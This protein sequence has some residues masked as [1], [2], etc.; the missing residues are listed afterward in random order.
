MS[1]LYIRSILLYSF[2]I[3]NV[4]AF[5]QN[6][7]A[8]LK[9]LEKVPDNEKGKILLQLA[10]L[11]FDKNPERA[12]EYAKRAAYI[13][14][15]VADLNIEADAQNISG[16]LNYRKA[17][18]REAA[19]YYEQELK[20]RKKLPVSLKMANAQYNLATIY[21]IQGDAK[22]ANTFFQSSLEIAK[23]KKNITLQQKIYYE[24]YKVAEKR[25]KYDEA[26]ANL[27]AYIELE[28]A[29]FEKEKQEELAILI[30]EKQEFE[31][32]VKSK[33]STLKVVDSTLKIVESEKENLEEL[34]AEQRLQ[35]TNMALEKELQNQELENSKLIR[36]RMFIV[37]LFVI[38][39][40]VLIFLRYLHK[41]K[42]NRMLQAKNVEISQQKEEI[43]AQRD[44][45]QDLNSELRNK[46]EE[47]EAQRDLIERKNKDITDSI[48]YAQRIQTSV[49][50]NFDILYSAFTDWFIFYRP[51]DIVS[52]DFYWSH[53]TDDKIV[54]AVADCTGHG[55][56]GAFMSML[57]MAFLNEI[58][59]QKDITQADLVLEVLR[60]KVKEFLN[61]AKSQTETKDGMDIALVSHNISTQTAQF[62]GANNPLYLIRNNE[63]IIYKPVRNPIGVYYSEKT[64]EKT[65]IKLETNDLMY[66]FSDG[67]ADQFGGV[68]EEKF[69]SKRFQQLFADVSTLKMGEQKSE[70]EQ[71]L[72]NWMGPLHQVDDILILGVRV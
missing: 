69:K 15:L 35:I 62:A 61:Q 58:V 34:T 39:L 70:I 41:Q 29:F 57:G 18:Y 53:K 54:F 11:N 56:P 52:G 16:T 68:K 10:T 49:L 59:V 33:D 37:I 72:K 31:N 60:T 24:L 43:E 5:A 3:I 23:S 50:P 46:N 28:D 48:I 7:E 42:S 22:K 21:N 17:K 12:D 36:Q 13:G 51:R 44:N 66:L 8:L 4:L 38:A 27:K 20:I 55:V 2:F 19:Y 65:D 40:A 26:L 67:Y 1:K 6:Q 45:L 9:K 32:M 47:I 30:S 14:Q 71:T 63:L 25:K 64:F